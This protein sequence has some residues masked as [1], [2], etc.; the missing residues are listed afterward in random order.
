MRLPAV[1]EVAGALDSRVDTILYACSIL[2]Y[3]LVLYDDMLYFYD[4]IL[5]LSY[6]AMSAGAF[7]HDI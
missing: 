3:I 5:Y 2:F 4:M 7:A 1:Y 6:F